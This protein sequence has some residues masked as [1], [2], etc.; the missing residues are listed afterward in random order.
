[1]EAT[2]TNLRPR[3]LRDAHISILPRGGPLLRT[4]YRSTIAIHP[5]TSPCKVNQ[6]EKSKKIWIEFTPPTHSSI[7]I[8]FENP[9]HEFQRDGIAICTTFT[10]FK[11]E[12]T[13][14]LARKNYI[15]IDIRVMYDHSKG[16]T[17]IL[18]KNISLLV[19]IKGV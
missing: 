3:L 10:P 19:T 13:R 8:F 15:I 11:P 18:S 9:S 16:K 5:E 7:L 2:T 17:L 6:F 1:M 14:L 4:A 12:N